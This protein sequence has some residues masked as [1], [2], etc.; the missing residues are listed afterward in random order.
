MK[1]SALFLVL[2]PWLTA[3][4]FA[5]ESRQD[6]SVSGAGIFPPFVSGN[7]VQQTGDKGWGVLGSYRY[8]LTPRSAVEFN[9]QFAQN[10]TKYYTSANTYH[11]HTRMQEFSAAYV[12]NFS[13]KRFNPFIE[14][15]I[16]GYRFSP[17]IDTSTDTLY[18]KSRF[19]PGFLYGGGIAYEISPSFDIRAQYRGIVM[20]APNLVNDASFNTSRYYNLSAP[21]I[22]I[23]YH[24]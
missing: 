7:G 10:H 4:A 8:M 11:V 22:G 19:T 17:I 23:A 1:K 13:F 20:K 12:L 3:A 18:T 14:G 5:Q 24:F 6:V 16:G 2:L 9:Y 15:G 21:A